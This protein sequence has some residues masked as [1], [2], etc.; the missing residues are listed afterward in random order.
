MEYKVIKQMDCPICDKIHDVEERKRMS[1]AT[2]KGEEVEYLEKYFYC[3]NGED[4]EC[5]F[6]TASLMNANLQ[7]A[8]NA[9]R[10]KH[11][12]LTSDEIVSLRET[13][14]LSQVELA[15]LMGWGEA[16]ISRYE[17]KSIQDE[18]YDVMLCMVRD[19]PFVAIELLDKH[20]DKFCEARLKAIKNCMIKNLDVY[21]KEYLSRQTFESN[22]VE[23]QEPSVFNGF[24][25]LNIDKIEECISYIAKNTKYLY[26]VKL[27]KMLWYVDALSMKQFNKAITGLVYTHQKMGALPV[28]HSSLVLL[29]RLNVQE[30]IDEV[31]DSTML[32]F[33]P[34]ENMSYSHLTSQDKDV[35]DQVIAKFKEYKARDIIAYMHEETAYKQTVME[36]IIP[37][38]LAKEIRDFT[39]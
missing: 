21:G 9:Y 12:L 38:N 19:S 16:T 34:V 23:Y 24:V 35:L 37:F 29:D 15:R 39:I 31:H 18:S 33:Y 2:I 26:K 7:A 8:K 5:E 11:H 30:E 6:E 17:S 22:Y 36:E 4:G 3:E 32:H 25:T 20:H 28:G 14:D 13:Y 10:K 1:T 27:M